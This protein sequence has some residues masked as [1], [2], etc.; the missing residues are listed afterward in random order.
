MFE[1]GDVLV[2]K[3]CVVQPF[4]LPFGNL[5]GFEVRDG[6]HFGYGI[7]ENSFFLTL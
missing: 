7:T 3:D 4:S 5:G 2:D 6:V 1:E